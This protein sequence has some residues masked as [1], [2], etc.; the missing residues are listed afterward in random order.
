[1]KSYMGLSV[2]FLAMG[3]LWYAGG[4]SS[5]PYQS[6]AA[7]E[8]RVSAPVAHENL[9]V[10]FI[11]GPDTVAN[12]QIMTL[13]EAIETGRAIVHETGNVNSLT[14]ENLSDDTELFIQEGDM[15]RGGRQDRLIAMD[16][17]LPPKS[18]IV[19]F[20]CNCVENGRWTNR[21]NEAP[22]HFNKSDQFAV[23]NT[24]K[25]ANINVQQGAVWQS[26]AENNVKLNAATKVKVTENASP[27][28]QQ[29]ALEN[30]AVKAKVSD[31]E[32]VLLAEGSNRE[33]VIGVLFLV[34]GIPTGHE[35]YCS[36]ALFRKAWPKL[37]RSASTEALVEKKDRPTPV[38]PSA[39]EVERYLAVAGR[40]EAST[41]D[42]RPSGNGQ[43]NFNSINV[44]NINEDPGLTAQLQQIRR[45]SIGSAAINSG[46]I[47]I[48][49]TEGQRVGQ[50]MIAGSVNTND[51]VI[52]NQINVQPAQVLD[53]NVNPQPSSSPSGGVGGTQT[54]SPQTGNLLHVN[55]IENTSGLMTEARDP[56]RQNAMIHRSFIQKP[57]P[58]GR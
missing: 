21:G 35:I 30:P 24:Q 20:P 51:R 1:M 3:G 31:Y 53:N 38:A 15:I 40:M 29:L 4:G 23:G 44:D 32:A 55:R 18:G 37:L 49:P 9:T 8:L 50:L 17:L 46:P 11:H 6:A 52:L 41:T 19:S 27:S 5:F 7:D 28:S 58:T 12:A 57:N 22:T 26:V 56:T 10:F 25:I 14:V 39:R 47:G 13:Q 33:G 45:H 2:L 16:M 48:M 54:T 36:N 34:N 43:V 42:N